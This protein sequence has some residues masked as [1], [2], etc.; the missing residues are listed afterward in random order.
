M[1]LYSPYSG[2]K[3]PIPNKNNIDQLLTY[4]SVFSID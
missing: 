3:P 2:L 4:G 1:V